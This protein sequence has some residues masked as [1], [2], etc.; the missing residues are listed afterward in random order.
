VVLVVG[1]RLGCINHALLSAQ[2]I[3]ADGLQLAGWIGNRID[4][5]LE[6]AEETLGILHRRLAPTPCLGV[7]PFA[8]RRAETVAALQLDRLE[9]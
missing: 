9:V 3:R 8:A 1:L 7:L 2:A 4:P 5:A 6:H